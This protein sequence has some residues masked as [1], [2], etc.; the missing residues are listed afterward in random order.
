MVD[1]PR[2]R[3]ESTGRSAPSG[4]ATPRSAGVAG[5]LFSV[6]FAASV[7][8]VRSFVMPESMGLLADLANVTIDNVSIVPA[9]LMPFAGI[10]FLWFIGVVRDRIGVLEDRFFA[11]VFLG[12]GIVF[13]AMLFAAASV[14][15]GLLSITQP[16]GDMT[17]LGQAIARAM[18]YMF[19]ARSAGVFTLVTSMIIL[20]TGALAKWTAFVGLA[21]GLVLLLGVQAFELIILLFPAWVALIS[22]IVLVA[23]SAESG[24]EDGRDGGES[25]DDAE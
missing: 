2:R 15:A 1:G 13:V 24:L 12:S 23:S 7:V 16:T 6:L 11:T 21:V 20:R 18:L 4:L 3:Q 10:A 17:E 8:I 19:G 22:V 25:H 9:Y 14:L 5:I